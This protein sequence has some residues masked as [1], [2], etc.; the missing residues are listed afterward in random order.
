MFSIVYLPTAEFI[1]IP[2]SIDPKS[3]YE[4]E[5]FLQSKVESVYCIE[6]RM[7][8]LTYDEILSDYFVNSKIIPKH[9]FEVIEVPDV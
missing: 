9:L 7:R 3:K 2:W 4:V 8:F 1:D 6:G 5:R